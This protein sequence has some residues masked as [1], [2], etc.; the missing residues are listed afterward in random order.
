M[1]RLTLITVLLLSNIGLAAQT[2]TPAT[3]LNTMSIQDWDNVF[4]GIQPLVTPKDNKVHGSPFLYDD[5]LPG[6]V[7]LGDSLHSPDKYQFKLNLLKNEIWMLNA[8]GVETILTNQRLAGLVLNKDGVNHT[9]KRLVLPSGSYPI[10]K[11][12]EVF[13]CGSITLIKEIQK[14]F[15]GNE[16]GE[17][18][19]GILNGE[20]QT[21]ETKEIYYLADESVNIQKVRL[22]LSD[23]YELFPALTK[24]HKEDLDNFCRSKSINKN[25]S[26][27]QLT[28]LL[29]YIS[30]LKVS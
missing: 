19:S 30:T 7:Y 17:K 18:G 6:S 16:L 3:K 21:Y 27:L 13:Y 9:F 25:L 28:E 1:N 15:F 2:S 4:T 11:F 20:E 8:S 29:R 22:K 14:Q 12:V 24:K 23:V 26:E 10:R 5:Y